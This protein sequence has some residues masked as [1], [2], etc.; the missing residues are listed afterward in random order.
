MSRK[1]HWISIDF[2][3]NPFVSSINPLLILTSSGLP[4]VPVLSPLPLSEEVEI[5]GEGREL[6]CA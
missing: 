1:F 6:N 4:A 3:C 5:Q 2:S